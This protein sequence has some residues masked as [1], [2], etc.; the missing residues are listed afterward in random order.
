M[1]PP[2]NKDRTSIMEFI[3]GDNSHLLT[4]D[5]KRSSTKGSQIRCIGTTLIVS[6]SYFKD[7]FKLLKKGDTFKAVIDK[8]E[9]TEQFHFRYFLRIDKPIF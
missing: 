4:S 3:I 7:V 9:D 2:D 5:T 6:K 8:D 1:L